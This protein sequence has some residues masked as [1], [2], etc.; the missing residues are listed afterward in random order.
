MDIC[1]I[2]AGY[3]SF[4]ESG[5]GFGDEVDCVCGNVLSAMSGVVGL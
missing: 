2:G 4:S 5:L 3:H 1:M